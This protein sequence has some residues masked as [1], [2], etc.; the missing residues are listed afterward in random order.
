MGVYDEF[1]YYSA[2]TLSKGSWPKGNEELF[3][4]AKNVHGWGRIHAVEW[5]K[6]ETQEIKDW[7]LFEGADNTVIPQYSANI[8]LQKA[9]AE[10][11][12]E[13]DLSTREYKCKW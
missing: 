13:G 3:I 10:N 11:R 1:T 6:P 5:I 2:R 9:E 7:L 12:L 8:C 4:L